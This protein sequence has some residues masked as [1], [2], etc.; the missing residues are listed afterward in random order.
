[1]GAT[2]GGIWYGI[3][4]ARNSPRVSYNFRRDLVASPKRSPRSSVVSASLFRSARR[5]QGDGVVLCLL[6]HYQRTAG[7]LLLCPL[8][9]VLV[10]LR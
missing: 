4:G 1:M 9:A 7:L 6:R 10:E 3:K 5:D 8:N 2:G